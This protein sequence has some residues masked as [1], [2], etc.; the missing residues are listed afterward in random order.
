MS[1]VGPRPQLP[2]A[3]ERYSSE[4]AELLSMRP[5]ITDTASLRFRDEGDILHG[6]TNPDEDYF[7]K[8]HPEKMRLSLE[9][10]RNQSF[11]LDIRILVRTLVA[12]IF[13]GGSHQPRVEASGGRPSR[14]TPH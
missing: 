9:Y 2:W 5:G 4:E 13:R 14:V 10:M 7:E 8:I 12:V 11:W 3:V 1:L 6:S